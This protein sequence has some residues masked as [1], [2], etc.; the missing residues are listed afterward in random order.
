LENPAP[1]SGAV[2]QL[3]A[4]TDAGVIEAEVMI[5]P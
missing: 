3:I 4:Q 2:L 1:L 5:A